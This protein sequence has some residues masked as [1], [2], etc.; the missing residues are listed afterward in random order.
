VT[1]KDHFVRKLGSYDAA[2]DGTCFR[3]NF[4]RRM[5]VRYFSPSRRSV[6]KF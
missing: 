4:V 5:A 2:S 3:M 1:T 6:S